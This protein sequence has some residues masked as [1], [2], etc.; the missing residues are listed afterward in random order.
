MIYSIKKYQNKLSLYDTQKAIKL[1][2]DTFEAELAK[3]LNL[4]RVS[5]PLFVYPETG[6]ND[7]LNGVERPVRF[8]ILD[9]KKDA[10]IVQS[11]AKWKRMALAKYDIH[12]GKGIYTDMNAIRRDETLDNLHSIYVDQWDWEKV[13]T[14]K[15]RN[16]DYLKNVV[17]S[18]VKVLCE[19]KEI[20]NKEFKELQMRFN[21]DVFFID[22]D[23]LL[24]MYPNLSPKERENAICKEKKTV[25][26]MR[27]GNK[28]SNG[29]LHDNRAPDY[30][31]WQLNG[32]ILVWYDVLDRAV[33]LS[34]MGIRV[35]KK[36]LVDQLTERGELRRLELDFHKAI[37]DDLV[38]LSIGGGIGQSRICL[39][40]L[41]KAHIGEV[42]ASLW[43]NKDI[44]EL[45]EQGIELL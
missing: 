33:E 22:S 30:D 20:I 11:L 15:E 12:I 1:A 42:Q 19:T 28:L 21:P 26:L 9:T 25:F 13:I 8:D 36:S 3:E 44:F 10:E 38:P 40:M 34:S 14:S 24:K 23:E 2:K 32:D 6:L 7:N 29:T 27:I 16:I 45:K 4:I 43:D 37:M 31:D 35:D 17:I 18:I 5:A 41:E 39:V